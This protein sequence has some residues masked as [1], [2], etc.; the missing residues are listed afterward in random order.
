MRRLSFRRDERGAA[1]VEF[2]L[3]LPILVTLQLGSVE[4][5]RAFEAQRRI[6]HIAA[7]MAD[8]IAQ[9]RTTTAADLTDAMVAGQVLVNPL[10]TGN[11]GLRISSLT[12]DSRGVV[13]SDWTQSQN[14][15]ATGGPS[16][17]TGYLAAGE[18]AIV[19][20]VT[21]DYTS[22]IRY[23]LPTTLHFARHAYVRPRLS[24]QVAKVG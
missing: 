14:W 4:L 15:S 2:A 22:P 23:L 10:P 13:T 7:A 3:M 17:P 24:T 20:D 18:S 19:A 11:M 9:G 6:A 21:Y 16:V 8:V 1:A 12:A 5:V